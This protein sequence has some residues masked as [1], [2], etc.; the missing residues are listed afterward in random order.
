[1][2]KRNL[3]KRALA[4][5][6]AFTLLVCVDVGFVHASSDIIVEGSA[7]IDILINAGTTSDVLAGQL[8]RDDRLA[9]AIRAEFIARGHY[10]PPEI[11]VSV[12]GVNIDTTNVSDWYVF[13]HFNNRA[14]TAR[15]D[16]V[17]P[18]PTNHGIPA[19]VT[20]CDNHSGGPLW[21]YRAHNGATGGIVNPPAGGWTST[22]FR[23]TA[24]NQVPVMHLYDW[25]HRTFRHDDQNRSDYSTAVGN[26][27]YD[28]RPRT[29]NTATRPFGWGNQLVQV[30][31]L[32]VFD[33]HVLVSRDPNDNLTPRMDFVGYWAEPIQDFLIYPS[34]SR[35]DKVVVFE[36]SSS[37]TNAHTLDGAGFL[38]NA[39]IDNGNLHGFLLYFV[40]PYLEPYNATPSHLMLY[41]VGP[42]ATSTSGVPVATLRTGASFA[43][44]GNGASHKFN[45]NFT[46]TTT[47][48]VSNFAVPPVQTATA[49]GVFT[50]IRTPQMTDFRLQVS[51]T[52]VATPGYTG[53]TAN[54]I[55]LTAANSIVLPGVRVSDKWQNDHEFMNPGLPIGQG[56]PLRVFPHP[57]YNHATD[58]WSP[59]MEVYLNV[60]T[61]RIT[62]RLRQVGDPTPWF[63]IA[64]TLDYEIPAAQQTEHVGFGPYVG[65]NS[66]NCAR[67]TTFTY[68]N[69]DMSFITQSDNIYDVL[70]NANFIQNADKY[71]IDLTDN[72]T[73]RN[74]NHPTQGG[75]AAAYMQISNIEYFTNNPR[76]CVTND[77]L[78]PGCCE[79]FAH[80]EC[81]RMPTL[82]GNENRN[83]CYAWNGTGWDLTCNSIV[84]ANHPYSYG[85]TPRDSFIGTEDEYLEYLIE[86]IARQIV[87][88]HLEK[89]DNGYVRQQPRHVIGLDSPVANLQLVANPANP[90]TSFIQ[91]IMRD[92]IA[93]GAAFTIFGYD[94]ESTPSSSSPT[95]PD[96][97]IEEFFYSIT[98]PRV[99]PISR[100]GEATSLLPPVNGFPHTAVFT[101]ANQGEN[102]ANAILAITNDRD[103]WP[104]GI[105]TVRLMV[106]DDSATNHFSTNIQTVTFEIIEDITPP[107]IP[108]ATIDAV[109]NTLTF[110]TRD[111]QTDSITNY[112]VTRYELLF[113]TSDISATDIQTLYPDAIVTENGGVI[114]A[115]F[116]LTPE[117]QAQ[118]Q[119]G[120]FPQVGPMPLPASGDYSLRLAVY[121]LVNNRTEVSLPRFIVDG[122][123]RTIEG[124][125]ADTVVNT[126]GGVPANATVPP[127]G[128]LNATP[129]LGRTVNYT[130][131]DN[132]VRVPTGV[133][134]PSSQTSVTV[135]LP[136][137][138][139]LTV[140]VRLNNGHWSGN[141][142]E[143]VR[144][145]DVLASM[146]VAGANANVVFPNVLTGEYTLRVRD[147]IDNSIVGEKTITIIPG[148]NEETLNFYTVEFDTDNGST[149]PPNQYVLSGEKAIR[150]VNPTKTG[151]RFD[152]WHINP[153]AAPLTPWDFDTFTVTSPVTLTA[154]W[155]A[156]HRVTFIV[157]GTEVSHSYAEHNNTVA[158]PSDVPERTGHTFTGWF[159]D[160]AAAIPWNFNVNTITAPRNLYAGFEPFL[161]DVVFQD[162]TGAT[163]ATRQ[164]PHGGTIRYDLE[165]GYPVWPYYP[166]PPLGER[167][168][169]TGWNPG[170]FD[171]PVTG[172]VIVTAVRRDLKDGYFTVIFDLQGGIL[173]N[174]PSDTSQDVPVTEIFDNIL[175]DFRYEYSAAN[176]P[177]DEYSP[178]TRTGHTFEGW[179]A[180]DGGYWD[181]SSLVTHAV[182]TSGGALTLTADW[183]PNT[184]TVNFYINGE[185]EK[186]E[187]VVY[188]HRIPVPNIQDVHGYRF[189]GWFLQPDFTD[190]WNFYNLLASYYHPN[191][192]AVEA[193]GRIMNLFARREPIN[194]YTVSFN[195][196]NGTAVPSQNVL[197]GSTA[198]EPNNPFRVGYEFAGWYADADL[199]TLWDFETD[200][201][202]GNIILHAKWQA[203]DRPQGT[204]NITVVD[205]AGLPQSDILVSIARGAVVIPGRTG[206]TD[207]NGLFTTSGLPPGEYNIVV[208]YYDSEG[209]LITITEILHIVGNETINI[210]IELPIGGKVSVFYH[211]PVLRDAG[212]EVTAIQGLNDLFYG[213][214]RA[215]SV[216]GINPADP[217]NYSPRGISQA[218]MDLVEDHA[219]YVR[220]R[221]VASP[222][223]DDDTNRANELRN[224]ARVNHSRNHSFALD[225]S[226]FKY[227]FTDAAD[228]IADNPTAGHYQMIEV[229]HPI[230][231]FIPLPDN[232]RG[233]GRAN[234]MVYRYHEG[235]P[236][237]LP[238]GA[239]N[240]NAYGEYWALNNNMIELNVQKFS[241]FVV[242]YEMPSNVPPVTNSPTTATSPS[243][244]S[245]VLRTTP[246]PEVIPHEDITGPGISDEILRLSD[247]SHILDTVNRFAYVHG[248]GDSLFWPE[249]GLT[250]AEATQIFYN[251]LINPIA[252]S[253]S[254]FTDV[255]RNRWYTEA[256]DALYTLGIVAGYPDGTFRPDAPVTRAEFATM[257]VNFAQ[258]APGGRVFLDV[259]ETHWAF[260]YI[261][262]AANF[263]W[264]SGFPDGSFR[265]DQTIKRGE[266]VTLVNRVLRRIPN[267][268][269]IDSDAPMVR[270]YDAPSHWAYYD[271]IEA[272]NIEVQR[273][274][275][276]NPN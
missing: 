112:G 29:H 39:G 262:T 276:Y 215:P 18:T 76:R 44:P 177:A 188:G 255:A 214:M 67:A 115:R 138:I 155:V 41:R 3:F 271:I 52:A 14:N 142:V 102:A 116:D 228:F 275:R 157:D 237:G 180:P 204:I 197:Y 51:G 152:D 167:Y 212:I 94:M 71:F 199:Q 30:D 216:V 12:P 264:I 89:S 187:S 196:N 209:V 5:F 113:T 60:S 150:P 231:I 48:N 90:G 173:T 88:Q 103:R 40:F 238:Q 131:T 148:A 97:V 227:R 260:D 144:N 164:V 158:E 193:A 77:A 247:V 268:A 15:P 246:Q 186:T 128:I 54:N 149:A 25:V 63:E 107:E 49:G 62:A 218:D 118:T 272:S 17:W 50:P 130:T 28:G 153:G 70:T 37:Q 45:N 151:Y 66:H 96:Y 232:H 165:G 226:V 80:L 179:L 194:V 95:E 61:H 134:K 93:N 13:D 74:L 42:T 265:P 202:D 233:G 234:Y 222:V 249:E 35:D 7:A 32:G 1:L 43:T 114:T 251:L 270:Y 258:L 224:Y 124:I 273:R 178:F 83:R 111:V 21:N 266:A 33:R 210:T 24:D 190:T 160:E 183:S 159:A 100:N 104:A 92:R 235:M 132:D 106:R 259:P 184:Y 11:R 156:M 154:R 221:L 126:V 23:F 6:M 57:D 120:V 257:A 139:D 56:V 274:Y 119:R 87:N 175:G 4:L 244:R 99:Q 169:Y 55:A 243:A 84:C 125:N 105:Y 254:N 143:L 82:P 240:A 26:R 263:G 172:P 72:G 223:A 117:Q 195:S 135:I 171:T 208:R 101:T 16:L 127:T 219:G 137:I 211:S 140:N 147:A 91:D 245:H 31:T 205:E 73:N 10:P 129:F 68:K 133:T 252:E 146:T 239:A 207:Q 53:N 236:H 185:F 181:F 200:V 20:C 170:N 242:A 256:I 123:S 22:N 162:S 192:A 110:T 58:S 213:T 229:N 182:V 189:D 176:D 75:P 34:E 141:I 145:N 250:R 261:S 230:R 269:L 69:L 47:A 108:T 85:I 225:L 168:I 78:N 174:A 253:E 98:N 201:V 267:I 241:V 19:H 8:W 122:T 161:Y 198:T 121:D 38:V 81:G 59:N 163:V 136:D 220:I 65:Y 9:N 166:T 191:F 36:I 46:A 86:E 217:A 206:N 79:D 27:T 2:K 109:N 64:P 203:V 248:R